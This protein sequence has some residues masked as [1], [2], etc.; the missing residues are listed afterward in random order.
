MARP[1]TIDRKGKAPA[2]HVVGVRVT[3]PQLEQLQKIARRKGVSVGE[4]LRQLAG[5]G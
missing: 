5:V 2:T 1:R 4:L 3:E